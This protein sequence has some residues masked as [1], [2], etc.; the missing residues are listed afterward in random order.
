MTLTKKFLAGLGSALV[1]GAGS[2][3]VPLVSTANTS[4]DFDTSQSFM[5]D[6]H[7]R[8]LA[9]GT[10]ACAGT[11]RLSTSNQGFTVLCPVSTAPAATAGACLVSLNAACDTNCVP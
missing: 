6:W 5:V 11:C 10:V 2:M 4:R 3:L 1:I 8:R 9:G 7:L